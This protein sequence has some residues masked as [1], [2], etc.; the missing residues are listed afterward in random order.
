MHPGDTVIVPFDTERVRLPLWRAVITII[1]NLTLG[2]YA[3]RDD[4]G[5]LW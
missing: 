5:L 1:Y 4:G 2:I 3:T